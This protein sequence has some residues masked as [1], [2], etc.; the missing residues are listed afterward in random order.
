[1]K[2]YDF[3]EGKVVVHMTWDGPDVLQVALRDAS[4]D[5]EFEPGDLVGDQTPFYTPREGDTVLRFHGGHS[6]RVVVDQMIAQHRS[7]GFR[8]VK[9]GKAPEQITEYVEAARLES[10]TPR[11]YVA[12]EEGTFNR[13]ARTF[14]C[15]ECYIEV[16]MPNGVAP[17]A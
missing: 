7:F 9:C 4:E 3:G 5:D 2:F 1:M 16:G 11:T 6:M 8:C 17:D 15:T 12:R 14:Y 13:K 10:I